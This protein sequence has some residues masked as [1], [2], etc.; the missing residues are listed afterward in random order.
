MNCERN[1]WQQQTATAE[2]LQV[3]SARQ[4]ELQ[5]VFEAIL[6]N[7]TRICEANFGNLVLY[8]GEVFHRVAL[9]NAPAAWAGRTSTRSAPH[10]RTGAA[11][12]PAHRHQ[13]GGARCRCRRRH[14]QRNHPARFTGARTLVLVPMLKG[15]ELVGAIGV[16]RQE[17]RPFSDK[18]IALLRNF[19]AQA[20]IA[21]ENARL[22]NELRQVV[23]AADRHRRRAQGHQPLDFR[24]AGRPRYARRIGGTS[25]AM[26]I[27][28][29]SVV[30]QDDAFS[31]CGELRPFD[32]VPANL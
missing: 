20:V 24:F 9:H 3:I 14:A 25:C 17:V 30:P 13:R 2:V 7:A 12:L 5:P 21:I 26:P 18:Q 15:G 16:Y 23:A 22:L 19:A 6:Q 11:A 1:R 31:Y 8:D 29:Q 28:A 32:G 10:P 4:G 27:M